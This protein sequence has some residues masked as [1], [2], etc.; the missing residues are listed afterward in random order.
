MSKSNLALSKMLNGSMGVSKTVVSH[1]QC[2]H[3]L[4]YDDLRQTAM[5]PHQRVFRA[6]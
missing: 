6:G 1:L 2:K 3:H 4:L 5:S